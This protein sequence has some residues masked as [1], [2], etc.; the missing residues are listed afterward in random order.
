[1][2]T[3]ARIRRIRPKIKLVNPNGMAKH[4]FLN[5]AV[6]HP[7]QETTKS[8]TPKAMTAVAILATSGISTPDY[9]IAS[10]IGFGSPPLAE[11]P[12]PIVARAAIPRRIEIPATTFWHKFLR[13]FE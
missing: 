10:T 1:M 8:R 12:T 7:R 5:L 9:S 6:A 2:P 11:T 13:S 3:K 4:G